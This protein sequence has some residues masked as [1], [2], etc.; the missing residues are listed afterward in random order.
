M[1]DNGGATGDWGTLAGFMS[2]SW[3]RTRV[4]LTRHDNHA[5]NYSN[6]GSGVGGRLNIA[7]CDG[8][9]ETVLRGDFH[10]VKITPWGL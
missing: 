9:C 6:G 8:H 4:P 2:T 3:L 7:F 1:V 10:R 5:S